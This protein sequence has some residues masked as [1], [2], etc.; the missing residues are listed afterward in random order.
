MNFKKTKIIKKQNNLINIIW[1]I[2]ICIIFIVAL[3]MIKNKHYSNKNWW[4]RYIKSKYWKRRKWEK[5][6]RKSIIMKK[7][8]YFK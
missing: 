1:I 4:T 7:G 3:V 5:Y 6:I 8:K 2:S